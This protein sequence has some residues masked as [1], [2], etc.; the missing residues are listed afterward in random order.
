MYH[1]RATT[2]WDFTSASTHRALRGAANFKKLPAN[3][4]DEFSTCLV[5]GSAP[6]VEAA[7]RVGDIRCYENQLKHYELCNGLLMHPRDAFDSL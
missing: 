5:R 1:D 4:T 7:I 2:R 3:F 6:L